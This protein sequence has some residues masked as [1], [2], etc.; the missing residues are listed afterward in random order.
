V[1]ETTTTDQK[2]NYHDRG[3]ELEESRAERGMTTTRATTT[4][5]RDT[6]R[7]TRR[8]RARH[9]QTAKQQN[10]KHEDQNEMR[11]RRH[12]V[13]DQVNRNKHRRTRFNRVDVSTTEH[14]ATRE[15]KPNR[16]V[17]QSTGNRTQP[18]HL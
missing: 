16:T 14:D 5:T 3:P 2:E 18:P 6:K 15:H 7:D 1:I 17:D 12:T 13:K 9:H 8:R 10:W 4:D 11:Q